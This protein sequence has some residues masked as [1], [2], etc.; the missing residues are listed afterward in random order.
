M[1]QIAGRPERVG[2]RERLSALVRGSVAQP[3]N[4]V[5][6]DVNGGSDDGLE[7]RLEQPRVEIVLVGQGQ[8]LVGAVHPADRHFEGPTGEEAGR[9]R[10][11]QGVPFDP[12]GLAVEA[13]P[14]RL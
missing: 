7:G 6:L 13:R 1:E 2:V 3:P 8:R 5:H 12:P 10:V 9:Q 11:E 14:A 4:Q